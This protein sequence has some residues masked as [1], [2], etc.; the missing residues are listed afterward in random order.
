M[1]KL[2]GAII[3]A[4]ALYLTP[5]FTSDLF[6]TPDFGASVTVVNAEN[7]G[8]ADSSGVPGSDGGWGYAPTEELYSLV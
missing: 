6:N 2:F 4:L 5:S 8:P 7:N 1:R 3:F